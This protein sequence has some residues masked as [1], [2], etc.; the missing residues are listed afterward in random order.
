MPTICYELGNYYL[1]LTNIV[2]NVHAKVAKLIIFIRFQLK[3]YTFIPSPKLT[4][5]R[6]PSATR[7]FFFTVLEFNP[8]KKAHTHTH[9]HT[10]VHVCVC[11]NLLFPDKKK[12]S[13]SPQ[14]CLIN[15]NSK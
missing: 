3:A 8:L 2:L 11:V 13:A 5:A 1:I 4:L 9:I 15:C 12:S 7:Y 10:Y 6:I 14:P